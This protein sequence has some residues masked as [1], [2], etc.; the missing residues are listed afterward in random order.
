MVWRIKEIE[1]ITRPLLHLHNS[2]EHTVL[3]K[4][5]KKKKEKK[6][7][8]KKKWIIFIYFMSYCTQPYPITA[9]CFPLLKLRETA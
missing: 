2:S 7:K 6:K 9:N 5:K 1:R 4:K 8:W 3:K